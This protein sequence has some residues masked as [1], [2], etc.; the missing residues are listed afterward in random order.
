MYTSVREL[1]YLAKFHKYVERRLHGTD[2]PSAPN[3][4]IER[5]LTTNCAIWSLADNCCDNYQIRVSSARSVVLSRTYLV[6]DYRLP[7]FF[8]ELDNHSGISL[9]VKDLGRLPFPQQRQ[10]SL[11]NVFQGSSTDY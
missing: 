5:G 9:L 7:K 10:G 3:E 11:L 6:D 2:S 8:D 1:L 4:D